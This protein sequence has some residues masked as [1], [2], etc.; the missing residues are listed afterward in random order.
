MMLEYLWALDQLQHN[1]Q[2][3]YWRGQMDSVNALR[4]IEKFK[5]TQ[6]DPVSI[7]L[8]LKILDKMEKTIL[9]FK[10]E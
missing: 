9:G 5:D 8:I 4:E 6:D 3:A 10:N 2:K 1:E 7:E